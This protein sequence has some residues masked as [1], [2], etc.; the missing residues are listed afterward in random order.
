MTRPPFAGR[1]DDALRAAFSES[2]AFWQW[3]S[4]VEVSLPSVRGEGIAL[5]L[6]GAS[7][8]GLETLPALPSCPA[9]S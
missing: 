2:A 7:F 9:V 1:M 5:R 3:F 4:G 6:P 8:P